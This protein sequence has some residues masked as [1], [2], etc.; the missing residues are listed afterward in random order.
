MM[1]AAGFDNQSSTR[2]LWLP[3][4]AE[5]RTCEVRLGERNA[6]M[7]LDF[8]M[9]AEVINIRGQSSAIDEG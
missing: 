9:S 2:A 5:L 4:V 7:L 1:S 6:S 8:G 3:D